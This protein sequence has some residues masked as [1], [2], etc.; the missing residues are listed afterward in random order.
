MYS[1]WPFLVQLEQKSPQWSPKISSE[2][3]P[4]N[5]RKSPNRP[6]VNADHQ[7]AMLLFKSSERVLPDGRNN[8]HE[9]RELIEQS[10]VS[11]LPSQ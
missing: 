2:I 8:P 10:L 1:V 4:I 3:D 11:I 9:S 6:R 5:L 7:K